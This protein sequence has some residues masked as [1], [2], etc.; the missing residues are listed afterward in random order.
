MHAFIHSTNNVLSARSIIPA[1][2]SR[3]CGYNGRGPFMKW[4]MGHTE[5]VLVDHGSDLR[6]MQT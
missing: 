4:T 2:C 1:Q 6:E 3:L 5:M